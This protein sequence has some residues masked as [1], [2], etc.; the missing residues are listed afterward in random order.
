MGQISLQTLTARLQV[1][2][3]LAS[4]PTDTVPALAARPEDA[5]LIYSAKQRS[6]QKPLILMAAQIS[7]VWSW[8]AGG[9]AE[10]MQWQRVAQRYWPGMVTLVLPA[11][12]RV[13][14]AMH[15]TD[16]ETLGFRVPNCAVA[17]EILSA[18]GPLATTS[19]NFSG[20]PPLETLDAINRQ[21]PDVLTLSSDELSQRSI[22]YAGTG[23]PST[24][25]KWTGHGWSVLR[26]GAIAFEG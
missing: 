8:T 9:E 17:R 18:T 12:D 1:G 24:V 22:A 5:P 20:Q 16:P 4:F 11:G 2:G 3:C 14:E 21:F 26:Q 6:P 10:L 25:V 15:P 7:E 13:P 19:V 23:Q